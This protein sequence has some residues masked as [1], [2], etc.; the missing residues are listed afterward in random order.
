MVSKGMGIVFSVLRMDKQPLGIL[1]YSL[2]VEQRFD[3]LATTMIAYLEGG[4]KLPAEWVDEYNTLC[5]KEGNY[6]DLQS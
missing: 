1:P 5:W 3:L 6:E 2:W 4:W